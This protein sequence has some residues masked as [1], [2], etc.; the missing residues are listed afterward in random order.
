MRSLEE[1]QLVC[2]EDFVGLGAAPLVLDSRR[3]VVLEDVVGI[4]PFGRCVAGI[5][6]EVKEQHPVSMLVFDGGHVV[7]DLV[8]KDCGGLGIAILSSGDGVVQRCPID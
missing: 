4:V 2:C 8:E 6:G 7:A 1:L 5:G 3:E